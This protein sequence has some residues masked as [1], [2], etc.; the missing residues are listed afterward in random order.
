MKTHAHYIAE[1]IRAKKTQHKEVKEE[2][3]LFL[4]DA[5]LPELDEAE[6]LDPKLARRERLKAILSR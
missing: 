4:D 5:E 2:E 6:P 3:S 1:A